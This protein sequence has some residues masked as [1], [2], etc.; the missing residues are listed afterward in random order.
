MT[1]TGRGK[2]MLIVNKS[3]AFII[4]SWILGS[5]VLSYGFASSLIAAL[6][7]PGMEKPMR[8]WQDLMDNNY[9]ILT[10]QSE[11][12]G[13]VVRRTLFDTFL[14]VIS[15]LTGFTRMNHTSLSS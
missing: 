6:S 9:T 8:T 12:N 4:V 1:L 11:F 3:S 10:A 5:A 15:E 13:F 14:T 2:G 7:R